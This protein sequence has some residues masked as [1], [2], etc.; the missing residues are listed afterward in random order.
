MEEVL[1]VLYISS[2]CDPYVK[3]GGLG[4]VAGALPHALK[5]N[6]VDIRRVLPLYKTIKCEASYKADYPVCMGNGYQT[7]VLKYDELES[8]VP[9]YFISND[10][11]FNR[12]RTYGYYEDGERFLFFSRAAIGILEHT[13]FIPDII[14]CNDWHTGLIPLFVKSGGLNIKTVYTIHNLKYQGWISSDFLHDN[15]RQALCFKEGI[16]FMESGIRFSDCITSVSRGYA[17]E[18]LTQEFGEGMEIHLR[19][20]QDKLYGIM[21]GIDTKVF[22]PGRVKGLEF[23]YSIDNLEGKKKNRELLRKELNLLDEDVPIVSAVTRLDGQKGIDILVEAVSN[24]KMDG[25]QFVILGTGDKTYEEAL[26]Y[27]SQVYTGKFSAI[28]AFDT[29]LAERIYAG[30]DIFVMPSRY[31]PGG[32]GQFYAMS[33]GTVPVVR[34]TG[35]LKDSVIDIEKDTEKAN[36]FCFDEYSPSALEIALR[37]AIGCYRTPIFRKLILNG[38]LRDKS[39][40]KPAK[41]YIELYE[42]IQK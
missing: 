26:K 31:E 7:C 9:T 34:N 33:Y 4:D 42:S 17:E 38:M 25:F 24:M 32:L 5:N 2:E 18:I 1:K 37:R 14:H 27:L 35:G 21:N 29:S 8:H 12:E 3:T 13:G 28:F 22:N 20:R 10:W 19:R 15:E 23:P 6:G 39:W 11:Y 36:G 16:N 40:D 30:S 41:E